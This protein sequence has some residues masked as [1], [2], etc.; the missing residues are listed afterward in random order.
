MVYRHDVAS[1]ERIVP[2]EGDP[3]LP[4]GVSV[5]AV[6]G[7][8]KSVYAAGSDAR[9]HRW[10][11][12]SGERSDVLELNEGLE[13]LQVSSDGSLLATGESDGMVRVRDAATGELKR[14]F[15]GDDDAMQLIFAKDD[16]WIIAAGMDNKVQ[17]WPTKEGNVLR[18]FEGHSN[19]VEAIAVSPDGSL[20]VTASTDKS[21][22][23]W[24]LDTGAELRSFTNFED[25]LRGA[26]FLADGRS[27]L[28]AANEPELWGWLAPAVVAGGPLE[29]AELERLVGEL[30]AEN[31]A[32]RN[33]ATQ[34]LIDRGSA[35][36]PM[37]EAVVSDDPETSFRLKTIRS[38]I[39]SAEYEGK[40]E[41]LT[42]FDGDIGAL[43]SDPGGRYWAATVGS[44]ANG[45]VVIGTVHDG[46]F[47]ILQELCDG[48]SPRFLSFNGDG[49]VLAT[50]NRD[51]S[52]SLFAVGPPQ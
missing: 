20:M 51:G 28:V 10:E 52:L 7:D 24:D 29:D 37:L 13:S 8:G 50:G 15:Q 49:T 12:E 2:E 40:M 5:L 14:E 33:D 18:G 43:A 32:V 35:I 39:R 44:E 25:S 21:A 1:G 38:R 46:R 6:T 11:V 27:F 4:D 17:V 3:I 42:K 48:H 22:R 45:R 41:V 19:N 36:L 26:V 23:L 9:I 30:S 47:E 31:F 16:Q 34:A